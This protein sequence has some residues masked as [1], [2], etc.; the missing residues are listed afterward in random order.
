MSDVSTYKDFPNYQTLRRDRPGDRGGG[1]LISLIHHSI[2]YTELTTDHLFPGDSII[3]HQGFTITHNHNTLNIYNIYIPPTSCCPP[4]Y[5]PD[6]NN[7]LSTHDDDTLIVG[8]FNAHHPYWYS[9]TEDDQAASR[10]I[11]FAE[12]LDSGNLAVLNLDLPTRLPSRGQSSS[13]DITIASTH[14]LLDYTWTPLTTL[15]SDHLPIRF[16]LGDWFPDPPTDPY[17]RYTNFRRARWDDYCEETEHKLSRE[18]PPVS[19]AAG[20]RRLRSVL[21]EA[22]KH[23]IP[24]GFI[25]NHLTRLPD[26]AKAIAGERDRLRTHNPQHPLLPQLEQQLRTCIAES[27]RRE[28][29]SEVESCSHRQDSSKFWGLISTMSGKKQAT[30]PNQP[31]TFNSHPYS[32]N[33][34]IA[35][36]FCKQFTNTVIHSSDPDA[37]LVRRRIRR[38]HPLDHSAVFLTVEAVR[39]AVAASG[40]SAAPGP[41]GITIRHLKHL[42]PIGFQYLTNLFNL[43]LQS[44]DIPS[45]WKQ[46]TIIPIPKAGKPRHL[47]A[48]YRPISLLSPAAKVLERLILPQ[49]THHLTLADSQHGF[50]STRSTTSAL[51][52]LVQK[53]AEGFNQPKPPLRTVAMAI[54]FS[55][56]FDTVN[57]TKLISSISST[58]L[59]HNTVRWLS[60]YLHGRVASCKYNGATSVCH[61]VRA[62]VPQG[63]V[64]SPHLFNFFISSYPETC[65]LQSSYA[66]DVHAAAS[67]RDVNEAAAALSRHASEVAAWAEERQLRISPSKSHITLFTSD[68]HQSHLHPQVLLGST[69]LPLER[70]PKILGVTF[71]PHFTFRNHVQS[72]ATKAIDRLKIL[73]ALAGTDW[74]QQKETIVLTYR[75]L[76]RSLFTYAAPVWFPNTKRT[77]CEQLQTIQNS[78]LRIATGCHKRASLGHLHTETQVLPVENHLGLL[79][80]QYLAS[81]LRPSHPSHAI[82]T[83]ASGPR[84]IKTTLQNRFLPS[85][86]QY[87]NN[88][89]TP[90]D[91]YQQ[92]INNIHTDAVQQAIRQFPPHRFLLNSPPPINP[93]ELDLPRPYRTTLSQLRS[94]HCKVLSGYRA[95]V[96]LSNDPLC[97]SC[98]GEP[99]DPPHLF[100]CSFHPTD[101]EPVDLWSRPV[102]TSHFLSSLPFFDFL[103]VLSPSSLPLTNISPPLPPPPPEPPPP[104]RLRTSDA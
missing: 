64:I 61:A 89:I 35:S 44:A 72:I 68:T 19:C 102:R 49:L 45:I 18:P 32:D 92:I 60:A 42:G 38:D 48:S 63:S 66:D 84:T 26:E 25:R 93:E 41:D 33:Y 57:H 69:P 24:S 22:A 1:G 104:R 58:S 46:A 54:D 23:H 8:D 85:I 20:E 15:N 71:D 88:N 55:K 67:A 6:L 77:T 50:R 83:R 65:E 62:G 78:A 36:H 76:I 30:P 74:G 101:L 12:A 21:L 91:S 97:P 80:S 86:A 10:G 52:P 47:G 73:K 53:V 43:S 82:V 11:A 81:A 2:S 40:N 94:G 7:F 99:H 96:G 13:P 34:T 31:I 100:N 14:F 103:P 79:C 27:K 16:Q 39:R 17:R 9:R 29:V 87:L 75:A 28:W 37:R 95:E 3:E 70:H 56:A 90:P 5:R 98:R 4:G 51:L 59:P